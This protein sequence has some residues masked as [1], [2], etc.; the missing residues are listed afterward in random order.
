MGKIRFLTSKEKH[1]SIKLTLLSYMTKVRRLQD[2][3]DEPGEYDYEKLMA[4]ELEKFKMSQLKEQSLLS[5]QE[6]YLKLCN[7]C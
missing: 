3:H 2:Y 6:R 5:K 4:Y 1:R 7:L